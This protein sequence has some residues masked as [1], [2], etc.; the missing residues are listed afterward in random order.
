VADVKDRVSKGLSEVRTTILGVQIF[1]GFQYQAIFQTGFSDLSATEKAMSIS[2]F[3]LLLAAAGAMIAPVSFHQIAERGQAT[4]AQDRFT[5]T[6]MALALAPFALAIGLNLYVAVRATLGLAAAAASAALATGAAVL[7]W[8]GVEIIMQ[9]PPASPP[10]A[11]AKVD[12]KERI[13]QMMTETRI[14]LPGVQAL[15]GFQ[16]AAYLTQPFKALSASARTAHTISLFLL[17]A[18]MILLMAPAPF[19]R[20]AER[21]QNTKRACKVGVAL[22]LGGLALLGLALAC[23]FYVA[24]VV[25]SGAE[26]AALIAASAVGV[27]LLAAW[28]ALP[29][30]YRRRG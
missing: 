20:I 3:L 17:L 18:S 26:N 15:L 29:A 4:R 30:M 11:D 9:K 28:F 12:L 10:V 24:L 25:V 6:A 1:L 23:D 14:V 16:Y 22:T 27:A 19:H 5:R 21:G 7:F 13:E 8:F 2:G